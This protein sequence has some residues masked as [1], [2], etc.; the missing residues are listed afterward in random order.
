MRRLGRF[1]FLLLLLGVVGCDHTTKALALTELSQGGPI[2][3]VRGLVELRYVT[4]TDTAFGVLGQFLGPTARFAIVVLAQTAA[5]L[6]L[7]AWVIARWQKSSPLERG[8]G[9]ILLGGGLGNLLDRLARG[10]VVDFIHVSYWPV[11]NVADIAIC[12][13]VGLLVLV[14]RRRVAVNA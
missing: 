14:W 2:S 11:F 4:N 12:V 1:V 6:A 9:A 7:T 10:H 8:A 5:N 13:G 3:V